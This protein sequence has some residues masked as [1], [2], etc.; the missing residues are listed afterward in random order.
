MPSQEQPRNRKSSRCRIRAV[1]IDALVKSKSRQKRQ[2]KEPLPPPP[3]K[4][5]NQESRSSAAP[6]WAACEAVQPETLARRLACGHTKEAR[7]LLEQTRLFHFDGAD[8]LPKKSGL[9]RPC[10]G[11]Q[12][13][14]LGDRVYIL[15]TYNRRGK[16]Q[17]D[18]APIRPGRQPGKFVLGTNKNAS[19]SDLANLGNDF[20]LSIGA[21]GRP[22][23]RRCSPDAEPRSTGVGPAVAAS[24][25][26]PRSAGA[27]LAVPEHGKPVIPEGALQHI[28]ETQS[29]GCA[30]S[31]VPGIPQHKSLHF[32]HDLPLPV[33][34]DIRPHRCSQCRNRNRTTGG[35]RGSHDPEDDLPLANFFQRKGLPRDPDETDSEDDLPLAE[36]RQ[37]KGPLPM[38]SA[39][40]PDDDLPLA[41]FCPQPT[42]KDWPQGGQEIG[43]AASRQHWQVTDDD[44]RREFPGAI[45]CRKSKK[46]PVWMTPLFLFEVCMGFH[47]CLNAR[48]LRRQLARIYST[49]ALSE[50]VR[51]EREGGAPY[52]FAWAVASL[53]GNGILREIV[54]KG[55]MGFIDARVRVMRRRQLAYNSQGIRCDGNYKLAKILRRAPFKKRTATVVIAFCGTDGSLLD[56][57]VPLPTEG[58]AHIETI[59]IHEA[60]HFPAAFC[61]LSTR[62]RTSQSR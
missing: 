60:P 11:L 28:R 1:A 8:D 45:C 39:E 46:A 4:E 41:A 49:N 13:D 48:E 56:V 29:Q 52:D 57:P 47:E 58:F 14:Y 59:Q 19:G 18:V 53:P 27:Q 10:R 3:L 21:R 31:T 62:L 54:L 6:S 15:D 5:A 9:Q 42:Q 25:G 2:R 61:S 44:I 7:L 51:I 12:A 24:L 50:Q 55:F 30:H 32:I 43:Q 16:L 37:R 33:R 35:R 34:I 22:E 17:A 23:L 38:P 36:F 20:I 26:M 40:D